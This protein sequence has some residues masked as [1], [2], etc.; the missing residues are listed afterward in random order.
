M[1]PSSEEVPRTETGKEE[2][3]LHPLVPRLL[4]ITLIVFAAIFNFTAGKGRYNYNFRDYFDFFKGA[5]N[6]VFF[7]WALAAKTTSNNTQKLWR[8]VT[9]DIPRPS[10]RVNM[11]VGV[12]ISTVLC[13]AIFLL[14][15]RSRRLNRTSGQLYNSLSIASIFY[16]FSCALLILYSIVVPIM[17]IHNELG[18]ESDRSAYEYFTNR[19]ELTKDVYRIA[20]DAN[21]YRV[22]PAELG[23]GNGSFKGYR[24]PEH[25]TDLSYATYTLMVEQNFIFIKATSRSNPLSFIEASLNEQGKIVPS[26]F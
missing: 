20:L 3:F 14:G 8:G 24:L 25:F 9:P 26:F 23:G 17:G 18:L 4:L 13:P 11:F 12:L 15:W 22:L 2:C 16:G 21:Q 7:P 1:S 6:S 10:D 5:E 19:T